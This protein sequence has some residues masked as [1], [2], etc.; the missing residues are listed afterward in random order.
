MAIRPYPSFFGNKAKN[1]VSLSL[2]T[3]PEN[4]PRPKGGPPSQGWLH[5]PIVPGQTATWKG[6]KNS[7]GNPIGPARSVYPPSNPN[8]FDVMYHETPSDRDFVLATYHPAAPK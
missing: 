4:I 5:T 6:H 1:G 2:S 7:K 8:K 3:P